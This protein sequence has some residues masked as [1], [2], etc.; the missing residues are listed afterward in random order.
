[1]VSLR[2]GGGELL[3]DGQG[4]A[5]PRGSWKR[6]N[7]SP[8][9]PRFIPGV[10]LGP[11]TTPAP[12]GTYLPCLDCLLAPGCHE[13]YRRPEGVKGFE[14]GSTPHGWAERAGRRMGS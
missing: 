7:R 9:R 5:H 4:E 8:S 14:T 1:M 11:Q 12:W 10:K 3:A 2:G 13:S 6:R